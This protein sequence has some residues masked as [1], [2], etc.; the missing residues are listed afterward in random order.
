M[1]NENSL[2]TRRGDSEQR[3]RQATIQNFGAGEDFL[4][5]YFKFEAFNLAL[6]AVDEILALQNE[7]D[8]EPM[9]ISAESKELIGQAVSK[10]LGEDVAVES[11]DEK[12]KEMTDALTGALTAEMVAIEG[13]VEKLTPWGVIESIA[14]EAVGIDLDSEEKPTQDQLD[15]YRNVVSQMTHALGYLA[16][17]EQGSELAFESVDGEDSDQ[18]LR[19]CNFINDQ[20][21]HHGKDDDVIALEYVIDAPTVADSD[22]NGEIAIEKVQI[23]FVGGKKVKVKKRKR[24]IRGAAL[25]K[26]KK[27]GRRSGKLKKSVATRKLMAKSM[28]KRKAAGM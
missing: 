28:K 6:E 4:D 25:A 5:K 11:V 2:L 3:E 17:T 24:K 14:C 26:M 1:K 21:T 18:L 16:G 20:L 9:E 15:D 12:T 8:P 22:E 13:V 10:I 19:T 7:A 27:A 23:K